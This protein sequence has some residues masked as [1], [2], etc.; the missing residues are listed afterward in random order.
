MAPGFANWP[1][2]ESRQQSRGSTDGL[3]HETYERW[4]LSHINFHVTETTWPVVINLDFLQLPWKPGITRCVR[5]DIS[6]KGW[7]NHDDPFHGLG[8]WTQ[9]K[10]ERKLSIDIS[11]LC[12]LTADTKC[13]IA[14]GYCLHAFSPW[15]TVPSN[16]EPKINFAFPKLLWSGNVDIATENVT[17]IHASRV[18]K[19]YSWASENTLHFNMHTC[20]RQNWWA[21]LESSFTN[22]LSLKQSQWAERENSNAKDPLQRI[23]DGVCSL[24]LMKWTMRNQHTRL[25]GFKP[26]KQHM[27]RMS[28]W[29]AGFHA[30]RKHL[31]ALESCSH[32]V[33]KHV[34]TASS[35][36]QKKRT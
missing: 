34:Q 4:S 10:G 12:F 18:T 1:Q 29:V 33:G 5:D 35:P 17:S 7:L 2:Q 26:S 9:Y 20:T 32:H 28:A 11:S 21:G 23:P 19:F 27:Q 14:S 8:T 24:P 15:W 22:D 31:V 6:R 3:C 13:T 25:Y 36:L 30:M 16:C